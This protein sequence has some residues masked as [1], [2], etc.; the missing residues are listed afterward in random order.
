MLRPVAYYYKVEAQGGPLLS[1][2]PAVPAGSTVIYDVHAIGNPILWWLST[3]AIVL[4][5]VVLVQQLL[6]WLSPPQPE[7]PLYIEGQPSTA[8]RL[9]LNA[10][11]LWL[12]LFLGINY[13]ANLLPWVKVTRC[14]FLYHYMGA[15]VFASMA[16]AWL[17][18]RWLH[19]RKSSLR[20]LGV[21]A[22]VAIVLAFIFWLPIYLGLPLSTQ[23]FQMRM[24]LPSWV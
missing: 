23:G 2:D 7:E 22:I 3:L 10:T 4:I 13:A 24:W 17:V 16:I 6:H 19:S 12:A 9:P 18:D 14:T 5:F 20:M 11:E 21:L 15:S 8:H 1:T